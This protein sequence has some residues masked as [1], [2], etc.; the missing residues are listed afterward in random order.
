MGKVKNITLLGVSSWRITTLLSHQESGFLRNYHR[1]S[2]LHWWH[3]CPWLSAFELK[4]H[5]ESGRSPVNDTVTQKTILRKKLLSVVTVSGITFKQH[6]LGCLREDHGQECCF[7]KMNEG[8]GTNMSLR[9]IMNQAL[10][11]VLW[12]IFPPNNITIFIHCLPFSSYLFKPSK[13]GSPGGSV[14]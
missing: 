13:Q 7:E 14:V 2:V 8:K 4:H 6:I 3:L 12:H 5:L 11:Q 1:N 9:P 10:W